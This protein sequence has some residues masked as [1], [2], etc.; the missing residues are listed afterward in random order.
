M[1]GKLKYR[2]APVL[3]LA[4]LAPAAASAAIAPAAAPA[5]SGAQSFAFRQGQRVYVVAYRRSYQVPVVVDPTDAT[6]TA[7]TVRQESIHT[8]LDGEQEVRRDL[9]KWR[10][11]SVADK[12]SEADFVFL[13]N[14]EVGSM[15]ALAIPAEAYRLHFK[16]KFDAD[17]LREAAYGRYAAG[18][19]KLPTLGRLSERLVKQFRERLTAGRAS[20]R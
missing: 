20:G 6:A 1:S 15:E 4:L 8:D 11:F 18:P 9:E 13:V 10:F 19:L 14:I 17:A 5:R 3:A 12:L 16:E 7:T 2:L